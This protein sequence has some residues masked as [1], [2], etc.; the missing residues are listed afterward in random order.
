M[1]NLKDTLIPKTCG[2]C[3]HWYKNQPTPQDR[4]GEP[5]QGECREGPPCVTSIPNNQGGIMSITAYAPMQENFVA[6]SRH[7]LPLV[8]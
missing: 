1:N 2:T 5:K 4:I 8:K 3:K 7:A 6:C